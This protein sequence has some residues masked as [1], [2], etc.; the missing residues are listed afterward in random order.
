M[1]VVV[2]DRDSI[3]VDIYCKQLVLF[4]APLILG[5][6]LVAASFNFSEQSLGTRTG[7]GTLS[8]V[9]YPNHIVF[10]NLFFLLITFATISLFLFFKNG[11][12]LLPASG[13]LESGVQVPGPIA[14]LSLVTGLRPPSTRP[15]GP[16][17]RPAKRRPG[18]RP[19]K[20]PPPHHLVRPEPIPT[21]ARASAT[22]ATSTGQQHGWP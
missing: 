14:R 19:A 12:P 9:F 21:Q 3:F 18:P 16:G 11:L 8:Y 4:L 2:G 13:P 10:W 22:G 20:R 15:G 17:P 1:V 7:V 6:M 5:G